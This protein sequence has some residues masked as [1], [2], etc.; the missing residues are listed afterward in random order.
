MPFPFAAIPAIASAGASIF[1]GIS[2]K[3]AAK[4]QQKLAE[5]QQKQ[6]QPLIDSA[7]AQ[8]RQS[9]MF[10][11]QTGATTLPYI[12]QGGEGIKSVIDFWKPLMS[13][14]TSA[15]NKFL[16]PERSAINEG[17]RALLRNL[18]R[19]AP[20]GGGRVSSLAEAE[21]RRQ[22]DLSNLVFGARTRGAE[23]VGSLNQILAQLG[24]SGAGIA[25]GGGDA[26]GPLLAQ[27]QGQ[28]GL[29]EQART[30]QSDKLFGAL[31]DVGGLLYD[32][33]NTGKSGG[34]ATRPRVANLPSVNVPGPGSI[35]LGSR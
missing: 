5:Q 24:L 23:Q 25:T 27:L 10:R 7:V 33:F 35:P 16:S 26:L 19:F 3:K 28:R 32:I 22:R 8:G 13:G 29:A 1:G 2:G 4:Q 20:R 18:T 34:G 30:G 12:S 9:N 15:I 17:Y 14:D 31:G 21:E 11:Q 6:L